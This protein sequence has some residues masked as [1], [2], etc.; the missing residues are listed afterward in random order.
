MKANEIYLKTMTFVW[1]KLAL[2]A[3]TFVVSAILLGILLGIGM[4]FGDGVGVIMFLIWLGAVGV[5]RL[6]LMH[7]MGYLVKAGHIAIITEALTNGKIPDQQFE[8]G[9]K[10]VTE[11]FATSNVYFAVDKLVSGAV[12]QIQNM[13]EKAGNLLDNIPGMDALVGVAKLFVSISLGYIDEC[14]LGYTFYKKEQGAFK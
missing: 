9:K 2:G 4:L 10:M 7:Y 3:V 8:V 12:K 14:C 11:R 1:L 6:A 13:L 5:I